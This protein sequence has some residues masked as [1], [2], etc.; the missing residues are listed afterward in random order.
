MLS[1]HPDPALGWFAR[2]LPQESE[3]VIVTKSIASE[4]WSLAQTPIALWCSG[5]FDGAR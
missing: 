3:K 4:N 2:L 5:G 1:G